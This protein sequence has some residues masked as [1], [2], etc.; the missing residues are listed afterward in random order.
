MVVEVVAA[1]SELSRSNTTLMDFPTKIPEGISDWTPIFCCDLTTK[2][3]KS[4]KSRLVNI[5]IYWP[6]RWDIK[7]DQIPSLKLNTSKLLVQTT[8]L[9]LLGKASWRGAICVFCLG[10]ECMWLWPMMESINQRIIHIIILFVLEYT[11]GRNITSPWKNPAG[12]Q[13][14]NGESS[15]NHPGIFR[16]KK[17]IFVSGMKRRCK[18]GVNGSHCWC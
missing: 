14:R 5:I 9:F 12:P 17:K 8:I 13:F 4:K 18:F 7:W 16:C 6:D 2:K 15:S 10:G 1:P 3:H 11:P